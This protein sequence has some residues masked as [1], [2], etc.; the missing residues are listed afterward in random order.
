M[1]LVRE[2]MGSSSHVLDRSSPFTTPSS[3]IL[4]LNKNLLFYPRTNKRFCVSCLEKGD[5]QIKKN[6]RTS[7]ISAISDKM[8]RIVP[9]KPV[10]FKVRAVVTVRNKNKEDFRE[11]IVKQLDAFSEKIGRNVV[12][13]LI[14][15]DT[16]PSK[17]TFLFH[18][19]NHAFPCEEEN[20]IQSL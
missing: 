3:K 4:G 13:E 7:P 11:T 16:D 20:M 14:S 8:G 6:G 19:V 18:L 2:F 10:K 1:A 17:L 5:S 9:E 12:L 15:S